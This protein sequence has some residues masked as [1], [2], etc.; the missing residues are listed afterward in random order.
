MDLDAIESGLDC[1]FG[2]LTKVSNHLGNLFCGHGLWRSG[3]EVRTVQCFAS[4]WNVAGTEG[5]SP[6]QKARR[7]STSGVPYL[8]EDSTT[9]G[10]Y[11]ISHT[12][13]C[14]KLLIGEEARN[15]RIT[16][17]VSRDI[18]SLGKLKS[19]LAGSLSV[20][21]HHQVRWNVDSFIVLGAPHTGQRSLHKLVFECNVAQFPWLEENGVLERDEG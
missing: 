8:T 21:L 13:P 19:S 11:S 14:G 15:P 1:I 20:V 6:A 2:G 4:D 16:A 9:F 12:L 17:S 18:G 7:R 10:V 3:T 5:L